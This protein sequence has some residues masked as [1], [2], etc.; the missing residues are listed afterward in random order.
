MIMDRDFL[1]K[2]RSAFDLNEYEVKIWT[3]LLSKGVATAGELAE[4]SEV[5]RSRSYDVLESLEKRGFVVVK[6][7][8][9][10]RYLAIKPEDVLSRVKKEIVSSAEYKVKSMTNVAKEDFFGELNLLYKNGIDSVDVSTL[11]GLIQ[12]RKN[13][14][15]Q[16]D[17]MVRNAKESVV[18][19]TSADGLIRKGDMFRALFKKLSKKGVDVRISSP[20]KDAELNKIVGLKNLKGL[21]SRFVLV[22]GKELLFML[23]KDDVH[24]K[25]DVGVW[26]NSEFFVNSMKNMFDAAWGK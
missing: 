3:A 17:S 4:M 8:K 18:I 2:L 21:D 26:V 24:D 6:L 23:T 5:P 14:Y 1:K 25:A 12:G 11:S 15:N 7:G 10:I 20:G 22:D 9:P 13:I 19:S 16:L